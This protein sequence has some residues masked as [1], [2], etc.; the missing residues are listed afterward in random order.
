MLRDGTYNDYVDAHLP[1]QH[2]T[3]VI[4]R[5][6]EWKADPKAR[7]YVWENMDEET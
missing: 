5:S 7:S 1:Y 2:R 4:R 3:G 6:D